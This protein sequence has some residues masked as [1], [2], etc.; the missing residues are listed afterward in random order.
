MATLIL[1]VKKCKI[2]TSSD[3]KFVNLSPGRAKKE[4]MSRIFSRN[5]GYARCASTVTNPS[6]TLTTATLFKKGE[7]AKKSVGKYSLASLFAAYCISRGVREGLL[8]A[9]FGGRS[10]ATLVAVQNG[11]PFAETCGDPE[12]IMSLSDDFY[13][14][15]RD[16]CNV[17]GSSELRGGDVIELDVDEIVEDVLADKQAFADSRV[18]Y[19]GV[20]PFVKFVGGALVLLGVSYYLYDGYAHKKQVELRRA[21]SV[22][23]AKRNN[24]PFVVFARDQSTNYNEEFGYCDRFEVTGFVDQ[25]WRL[26]LISSGWK[27]DEASLDCGK[28]GVRT[29]SVVYIRQG[30]TNQMIAEAF[31]GLPVTFAFDLS[32]VR[33]GINMPKRVG[34]GGAIPQDNLLDLGEFMLTFGTTFQKMAEILNVDIG[35]SAPVAIGGGAIPAGYPDVV[36][37][38][39]AISIKGNSAYLKPF[40]TSTDKVMR[41]SGLKFPKIEHGVP[42]FSLQGFFY[43]KSGGQH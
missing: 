9:Y 20:S 27:M 8:I 28:D 11:V 24:D 39:G 14:Y 31:K 42:E 2:V 30:G 12:R 1:D 3:T 41:F 21:Q 32:K 6:A 17:Y 38:K 40:M 13:T 33:I 34:D 18:I 10:A 19:Y 4:E 22:A 37:M 15:F 16:G 5:L 7:A 26:P 35:L 29:G 43:V 23:A 36:L 25:V